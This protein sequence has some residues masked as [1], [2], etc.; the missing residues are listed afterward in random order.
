M[1][2]GGSGS[3]PVL[4]VYICDCGTCQ[5]DDEQCV[6][7]S[8]CVVVTSTEGALLL[9]LTSLLGN[10][11]ENKGNE[12]EGVVYPRCVRFCPSPPFLCL[13]GC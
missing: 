3:F 12:D 1:G 13:T 8:G 7:V 11:A 10:A 6:C 9:T 5:V 4:R 2:D